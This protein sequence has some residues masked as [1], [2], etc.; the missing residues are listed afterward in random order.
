MDFHL[1]VPLDSLLTHWKLITMFWIKIYNHKCYNLRRELRKEK[2]ISTTSTGSFLEVNSK[3]VNVL[4]TFPEDW[5]KSSWLVL[6]SFS[7][8]GTVAPN[9]GRAPVSPG[10]AERGKPNK[11]GSLQLIKNKW[12]QKSSPS[13]L[14]LILVAIHSQ[15]VEAMWGIYQME[16]V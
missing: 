9:T 15:H 12:K 2:R 3:H 16:K 10:S 13:G 5:V 7:Q 6:L 1:K 8:F 14:F 4:Q 11:S